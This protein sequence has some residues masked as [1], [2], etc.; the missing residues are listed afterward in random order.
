M[1]N[2][3]KLHANCGGTSKSPKINMQR[4]IN[5]SVICWWMEKI[6]CKAKISPGEFKVT[7][8]K[9]PLINKQT[10]MGMSNL[11]TTLSQNTNLQL[12]FRFNTYFFFFLFNFY[13]ENKSKAM[14][15]NKERTSIF[16]SLKKK[17]IKTSTIYCISL[18]C[19]PVSAF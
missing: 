14:M 8:P 6:S 3:V 17:K 10:V 9:N 2:Y 18:S 7:N 15:Q 16:F 5:N 13:W 1:I 19:I 12:N 4:K 11:T